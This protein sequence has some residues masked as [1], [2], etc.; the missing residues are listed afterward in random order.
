MACGIYWDWRDVF[1]AAQQA[2]VTVNPVDTMG[3]RISGT[4][5]EYLTV[6]DNTGGRAIVATNDFTPGIRRIFTENSSYYL[7]A[8]QPTHADEDGTFRRIAVKVQRSP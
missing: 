1:A 5:D 4:R 6:A 7:L 2:H 3:L 8:Y